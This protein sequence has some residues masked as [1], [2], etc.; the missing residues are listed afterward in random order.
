MITNWFNFF[1]ELVFAFSFKWIACE[2]RTLNIFN[3]KH[4]C[5]F[6]ACSFMFKN[7]TALK[8]LLDHF[9]DWSR[10]HQHQRIFS[11][12]L[13]LLLLLSLHSLCFS[14]LLCSD[15]AFISCLFTVH[16]FRLF[17]PQFKPT[18]VCLNL[19]FN[20]LNWCCW[21]APL[22][23][24]FRKHIPMHTYFIR[25]QHKKFYFRSFNENW[26]PYMDCGWWMRLSVYFQSFIWKILDVWVR[27]I[28]F[29]HSLE[30]VFR[31]GIDEREE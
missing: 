12:S 17:H 23:L 7:C 5:L 9:P 22:L 28:L 3:L 24:L 20:S 29:V 19:H 4:K 10:K 11:P 16:F 8:A 21:I 30:Y 27:L 31:T 6:I 26:I 18:T 2:N 1:F 25:W 15:D 13:L 14:L